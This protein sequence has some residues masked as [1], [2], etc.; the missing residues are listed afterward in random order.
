MTDATL[1]IGQNG[2]S[3]QSLF[4]LMAVVAVVVIA[5]ILRNLPSQRRCSM[6]SDRDHRLTV[7]SDTVTHHSPDKPPQVLLLETLFRVAVETNDLG[8]FE[9]QVFIILEGRSIDSNNGRLLIPQGSSGIESLLDRLLELPG[10]DA[11]LWASAIASASGRIEEVWTSPPSSDPT[12]SFH[13]A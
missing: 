2:G 3:L 4:A 6:I 11:D 1:Q 7:D 8:P 10:F 12:L 5:M 13:S 9:N